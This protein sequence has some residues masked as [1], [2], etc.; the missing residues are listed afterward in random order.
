MLQ[1]CSNHF[2]SAFTNTPLSQWICLP[3]SHPHFCCILQKL[4]DTKGHSQ[5]SFFHCLHSPFHAESWPCNSGPCRL[6]PSKLQ[7]LSFYMQPWFIDNPTGLSLNI[8][9]FPRTQ[10]LFSQ[11]ITNTTQ[12]N[13]IMN[14]C[15]SEKLFLHFLDNGLC[16]VRGDHVIRALNPAAPYTSKINS[17][18]SHLIYNFKTRSALLFTL[19]K[20]NVKPTPSI[21]FSPVFRIFLFLRH[22]HGQA[23]RSIYMD[24]KSIMWQTCL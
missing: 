12:L 13:E 1:F 8:F 10:K 7:L 20:N 2:T 23:H 4:L 11:R 16:H 21:S 9:T 17:N 22:W 19:H 3:Y 18:D 14:I 5:K 24:M 15:S 6:K